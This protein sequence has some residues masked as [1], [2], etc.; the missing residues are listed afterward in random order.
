MTSER[1]FE[2]IAAFGADARRWPE[3]ERAGVM[4]LAAEDAAVRAA[5]DEAR[6]LDAAIAAM[7]A[8]A[9][10]ARA[11][12]DDAAAADAVLRAAAAQEAARPRRWLWPGALAAAGLAAAVLLWLPGPTPAPD[13]A[14]EVALATPAATAADQRAAQQKA[15]DAALFSLMFTSTPDEDLL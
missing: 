5:L 7:L 9:A 8:D 13:G 4:A 12:L 2:I 14:P 6:A 11:R 1:A 15:A 10:P 3:G